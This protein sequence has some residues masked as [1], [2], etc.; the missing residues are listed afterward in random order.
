MSVEKLIECPGALVPFGST[1]LQAD[2]DEG[3]EVIAALKAEVGPLRRKCSICHAVRR[4]DGR[5]PFYSEQFIN[6]LL[7]KGLPIVRRIGIDDFH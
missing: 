2:S 6:S 4:G 1:L 5:K 7:R 3:R